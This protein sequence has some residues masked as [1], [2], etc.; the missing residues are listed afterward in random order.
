MLSIDKD[1]TSVVYIIYDLLKW[2]EK[3][4]GRGCDTLRLHQI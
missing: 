4:T 1:N 2:N 3:Y